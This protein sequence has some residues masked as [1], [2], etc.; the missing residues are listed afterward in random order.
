MDEFL[1]FFL[2]FGLLFLHKSFFNFL[3]KGPVPFLL[4]LYF[5]EGLHFQGAIK[6]LSKPPHG[7]VDFNHLDGGSIYFSF[8]P[9]FLHFGL[10]NIHGNNSFGSRRIIELSHNCFHP[11]DPHQS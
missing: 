2:Y 6:I 7:L 8:K 1:S 4:L 11:F 10:D 9:S 3:L 5:S